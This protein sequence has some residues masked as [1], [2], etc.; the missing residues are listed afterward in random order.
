VVLGGPQ[1]F[2]FIPQLSVRW[3]LRAVVRYGQFAR[4]SGEWELNVYTGPP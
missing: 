2:P 3:Y 4:D 1:A